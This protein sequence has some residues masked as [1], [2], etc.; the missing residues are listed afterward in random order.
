M[1]TDAMSGDPHFRSD[2][3]ALDGSDAGIEVPGDLFETAVT[4]TDG[5]NGNYSASFLLGPTDGFELFAVDSATL[6]DAEALVA[7]PEPATLG[8][9]AVGLLM[10]RRGWRGC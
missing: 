4:L 6:A 3:N 10:V 7:V 2:G 9:L 1:L 8:V 5:G